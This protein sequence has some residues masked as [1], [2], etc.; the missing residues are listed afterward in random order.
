[1]G[2]VAKDETMVG[3]GPRMVNIESPFAA[4]E[5]GTLAQHKAYLQC[6][7]LDSILRGEIPYA[8]HQMYTEALVD[9]DPIDRDIGLGVGDRAR[10]LCRTVLYSDFGMSPG[11]GR[12]VEIL[13]N[14]KE[15]YAVRF[16]FPY[17]YPSH[18]DV[19]TMRRMLSERVR[20]G[21]IKARASQ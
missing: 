21:S 20:Q 5:T 4:N 12:A 11:M 6:C 7:I 14:R 2:S 10:D 15:Y 16:L 19:E 13:T 1:M 8:S 9:R 17:R 3:S 18:A